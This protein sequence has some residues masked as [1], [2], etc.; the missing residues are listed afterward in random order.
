MP[1]EKLV[2][3]VEA[4]SAIFAGFDELSLIEF[5][6]ESVNSRLISN[7]EGV[8]NETV[9]PWSLGT[10]IEYKSAESPEERMDPVYSALRGDRD[11]AVPL[12]AA[13]P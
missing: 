12:F 5:R 1:D 3:L 11:T 6:L 10:A 7:A 2:L 8:I 13:S 9:T 4:I